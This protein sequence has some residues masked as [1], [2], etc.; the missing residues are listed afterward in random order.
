MLS[1]PL[2]LSVPQSWSLEPPQN[3]AFLRGVAPSGDLHIAVSMLEFMNDYNRR[4]FVNRAL[5]QSRQHPERIQIRQLTGNGG[6]QILQKIT[7]VNLPNDPPGQSPP[8]TQPSQLLSW[9][10][11]I[12]V[13]YRQEFIPCNFNLPNLTQQQYDQDETFIESIIDT[14]RQDVIPAF[15]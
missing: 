12:F 8:A 15:Q 3:P 9:N 11:T 5:D 7:Y 13:P 10:I 6:L 14:A 1:V 4:L 2:V